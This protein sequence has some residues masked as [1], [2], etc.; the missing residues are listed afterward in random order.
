MRCVPRDR[1]TFRGPLAAEIPNVTLTP[2]S[3]SGACRPRGVA[4]RRPSSTL[5]K[6]QAFP[7][8]PA[9]SIFLRAT[10]PIGDDTSFSPRQKLP[11]SCG[12]SS[13]PLR[14]CGGRGPVLRSASTAD[15]SSTI[16]PIS[17]NGPNNRA[18]DR[19]RDRSCEAA[20]PCRR[21][22]RDSSPPGTRGRY[23]DTAACLERVTQ[24]PD[25]ALCRCAHFSASRR[26]CRRSPACRYG[27]AGSQQDI[28]PPIRLPAQAC[29]R[30]R[31][32]RSLP[33]LGPNI[34]QRP[35]NG[36]GAMGRPHRPIIAG[37]A[38]LSHA[39]SSR[40]L[41][42][43]RSPRQLRQPLFRPSRPRT[44]RRPRL[45]HLVKR[46]VSA[47]PR[48]LAI[49]LHKINICR[50]WRQKKW[51]PLHLFDVVRR[52]SNVWAVPPSSNSRAVG[53][54]GAKRATEPPYWRLGPAGHDPYR[55]ARCPVI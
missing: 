7:D 29:R 30:G 41:S 35:F 49:P 19:P 55:A 21:G 31:G 14:I 13:T 39:C 36:A 38:R 8:F 33:A 28:S 34:C 45:P 42:H 23:A 51:S 17:G 15:A 4:E 9:N 26:P 50:R 5:P 20:S 54:Y 16:V 12:S 53:L 1:P 44:H 47:H 32:R 27:A 18:G 6:C 3:I 46:S 11:K 2:V 43:R 48:T 22:D 37:L 25:R 24:R 40:V 52:N 10:W